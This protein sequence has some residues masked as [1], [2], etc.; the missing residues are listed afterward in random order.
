MKIQPWSIED[1]PVLDWHETGTEVVGPQEI[2]MRRFR[3]CPECHPKIMDR[4]FKIIPYIEDVTPKG[5][6][7]ART[8]CTT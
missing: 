4:Y 6:W 3:L 7:V 1:L 8:Y 2:Q 5:H